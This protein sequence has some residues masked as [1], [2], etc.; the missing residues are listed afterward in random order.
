LS[1]WNN[2][3]YEEVVMIMRITEAEVCGPQLLRLGF[4]NGTH[5]TVDVRSLLKGPVFEPLFD[6]AFFARATL[7]HECGTVVWPNGADFAPEA[8]HDLAAVEE[9]SAVQ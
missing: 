1:R 4:N 6:P 5:K 9:P 3:Q 2:L 7:D 8:L